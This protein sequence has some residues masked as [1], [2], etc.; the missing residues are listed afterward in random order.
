MVNILAQR[1]THISAV[2]T[3]TTNNQDIHSEM[4]W[5]RERERWMDGERQRDTHRN[6]HRQTPRQPDKEACNFQRVSLVT[7][8]CT[9]VVSNAHHHTNRTY[10]FKWVRYFSRLF[11]H[12]GLFRPATCTSSGFIPLCLQCSLVELLI[13]HV[14]MLGWLERAWGRSYRS[15]QGGLE[16]RDFNPFA[17]PACKISGLK[18]RCPEAPANSIFS[19]PMTHLLSMLCVSM[20]IVWHTNAKKKKKKK[21]GGGGGGANF[22]L[23]LVFFKWHHGSEWV[24]ALAFCLHTSPSY[25]KKQVTGALRQRP[26]KSKMRKCFYWW[27]SVSCSINTYTNNNNKKSIYF[28]NFA[29]IWNF[30]HGAPQPLFLVCFLPMKVRKKGGQDV[31]GTSTTH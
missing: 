6:R 23:L 27:V 9:I 22:A 3:D 28:F 1:L 13:R 7:T 15:W 21:R 8:K 2:A 18:E 10:N 12:Q 4:L 31:F 26:E 19:S 20:K 30:S 17:V 25:Y 29:L 14:Y 16:N 24:N 11:A 5:E